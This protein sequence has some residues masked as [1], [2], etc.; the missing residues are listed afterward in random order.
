MGA[1]A[2]IAIIG[3]GASGAILLLRLNRVFGDQMLVKIVDPDEH[4]GWGRAYSTSDEAHLL[5]VS[6][7]NMSVFDEH[8]LDFVDWLKAQ[9]H[10]PHQIPTWPFVPRAWFGSYLSQK[11][12]EVPT[13]RYQHIGARAL[14]LRRKAGIWFVKTDIDHVVEADGVVIA[15]GFEKTLSSTLLK[16]ATSTALAWVIQPY[17]TKKL[18][19]IGASDSVVIVGTGLTAIDVY[20]Q[21]RKHT[22]G[23]IHFISRHGFLP[24]RHPNENLES[25]IRLPR[26]NGFSPI[27]IFQT[28][29]AFEKT[30]IIS[31]IQIVNQ[32]R[33]QSGD[34]WRAWSPRERGQFFRHLK[35]YWEISR[36]RMPSFVADELLQDA[37][38]GRVQ[39]HPGRIISTKAAGTQIQM[40]F[41][42]RGTTTAAELL[43]EW[44]IL[45]T[46]SKIEESLDIRQVK[47]AVKKSQHGLGYVNIGA[48]NLWLLGPSAKASLWESTAVPEIVSQALVISKQIISAFHD[49]NENIFTVHPMA[50]G[51]TYWQHLTGALGYTLTFAKTVIILGIHAL[52]PFLFADYASNRVRDLTRLF[53]KR[54]LKK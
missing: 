31:W 21:L 19:E 15:T 17:D 42:P 35:T 10:E 7:E 13:T 48:G 18:N 38:N 28:L 53:N 36:H 3:G 46:D 14:S 37:A 54:R 41:Q 30:R 1:K 8:P 34:I 4:L 44:I 52:L 16:T 40:Q 49:Q 22:A 51:Q 33:R 9:G 20:R 26:L 12:A 27:Q 39:I 47:M 23:K 25:E 45:A 32:V 24:L 5:N 6:A 29:R 11:I 43:C 2:T 50:V